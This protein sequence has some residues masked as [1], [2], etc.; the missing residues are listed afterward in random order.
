MGRDKALIEVG[1]EAMA[2]KVAAVLRAAGCEPV[3]AVGGDAHGLGEAGL[4]WLADDLPGEGPVAGVLTAL[5]HIEADRTAVLACDLPGVPVDVVRNLIEAHG[6]GI[7]VAMADTGRLEPL[8]AVWHRRCAD[9]LAARL[10]AGVRAV[11]E[12]VRGLRVVRV[13]VEPLGL[14]N[15]NTPDDLRRANDLLR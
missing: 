13:R 1:G 3:V 7:D 6:T 4:A 2:A 10:D 12:A 5:R 15:V 14:W 11:H 8:C 9:H